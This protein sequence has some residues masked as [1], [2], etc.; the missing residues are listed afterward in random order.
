[1]LH[2]LSLQLLGI[3]LWTLSEYIGHRFLLHVEYK[4]PEKPTEL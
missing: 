3:I 2:W 1:M 4:L